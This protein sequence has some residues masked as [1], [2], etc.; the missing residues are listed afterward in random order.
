MLHHLEHIST[1]YP[2][3]HTILGGDWNFGLRDADATSTSR[4]PQTEAV[5]RTMLD[6]LD[7][8]NVA[9]MSIYP[10][11]NHIL[12]ASGGVRQSQI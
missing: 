6:T 3:Q 4:K 11:R 1:N 8:Y 2:I 7:L 9:A 5:C 10:S 12:P